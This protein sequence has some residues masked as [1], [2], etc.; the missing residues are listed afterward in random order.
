MNLT[1][2]VSGMQ[3]QVDSDEPGLF[4]PED[5]R[6]WSFSAEQQVKFLHDAQLQFAILKGGTPG[7]TRRGANKGMRRDVI[8]R[9]KRRCRYCGLY[10]Q[11]TDHIHIDHVIPHSLG[12]LTTLDNLVA[13]CGPC[14]LKKAGKTLEE[15]GMVL[16]PVPQKEGEP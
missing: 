1:D 9:D 8:E 2:S 12:G 15:A 6:F 3:I 16:L 4:I 14:N 10:I 13:T 7:I 5:A 11:D